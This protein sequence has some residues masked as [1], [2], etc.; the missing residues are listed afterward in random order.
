MLSKFLRSFAEANKRIIEN[1]KCIVQSTDKQKEKQNPCSHK[2][3]NP[4]GS[5]I[6]KGNKDRMIEKFHSFI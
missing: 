4:F 1:F 2:I 3:L 6:R 5:K